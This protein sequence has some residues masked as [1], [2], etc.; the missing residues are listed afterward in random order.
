MLALCINHDFVLSNSAS[1]QCSL[2][3]LT[4]RQGRSYPW[5]QEY[6]VLLRSTSFQFRA[7]KPSCPPFSTVSI[8]NLDYRAAYA[9]A[10]PDFEVFAFGIHTGRDDSPEV[11]KDP[12]HRQSKLQAAMA[13][14]MW[15]CANVAFAEAMKNQTLYNSHEKSDVIVKYQSKALSDLRRRLVADKDTDVLLWTITILMCLDISFSDFESWKAH[16]EGLERILSMRGGLESLNNNVYLKHKIIGFNMFWNNKQ[17]AIATSQTSSKYPTH[18]FPPHICI[19]IS[20]L[21]RELSDLA[22]DGCFNTALISLMADVASVSSKLCGPDEKKGEDLRRLKLLGY[23]LEELFRI[24]TLSQLEKLVIAALVD[25][26]VSMD[27]DRGLHWLLMG[28]LRMRISYLWCKGVTYIKKYAKAFI[29]AGAML[30]ACSEMSSLTFRLGS[31]VL[32]LCSEHHALDKA[33][34]LTTCRQFLWDDFLTDKLEQKFDFDS[35]P[36]DRTSSL[37]ISPSPTTTTPSA[38]TIKRSPST[39]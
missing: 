10:A 29:W 16:T 9:D 14:P 28:A 17:L 32:S 37:S 18:P 1:G 21:P 36:S 15:F 38:Q 23:E 31:N 13:D 19:A 11:W 25:Y 6:R 26:C 8:H 24:A 12:S 35:T 5:T 39:G 3:S 30:A 4:R 7:M 22:L 34:V 27:S 2:T 33:Y 20:K